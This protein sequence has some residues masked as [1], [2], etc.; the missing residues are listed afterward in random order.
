MAHSSDD[1]ATTP[2]TEAEDAAKDPGREFDSIVSRI[3][4]EDPTAASP[5]PH[6]AEA[7]PAPEPKPASGAR[8]QPA[9]R[10]KGGF[11]GVFLGGVCAAMLGFAAATYVLP[12]L[13]QGWL[14]FPL[15]DPATRA[16]L[17]AQAARIESMAQEIA[18]LQ[19]APAPIDGAKLDAELAR[20]RDELAAVPA[21]TPDLG[22]LEARLS[23]LDARLSIIEK[24]PVAGGA[25]SSTAIDALGRELEA[26]RAEVAQQQSAGGGQDAARI[27]AAATEAQAQIK[28][29]TEE[30][31]RLKSEAEDIARRGRVESALRLIQAGMA[32]GGPFGAAI[33]DLT[34]AGI[35]VPAELAQDAEGI[36][37]LDQLRTSFPDSARQA[38]LVAAKPAPGASALDRLGAFLRGQS[39]AR[40]LTPRAG[41]DPDAI[42]SRAEA[43]LNDGDLAAALNEV[44]SL[45][46]EVQAPMADWIRLTEQR[47]A[48]LDAVAAL[49]AKVN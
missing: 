10:R 48:A 38:L 45:P 49:S 43:A 36:P 13:P 40:S 21:V 35:E 42:L 17:D 1:P 41:T 4:S 7:D 3:E 26:L 15:D 47:R 16:T 2:P 30:A 24:R 28:A 9:P 46:A 25:A 19:Q 34:A 31:A 12:K 6:T 8:I 32:S 33:E 22:P 18:A 14:P 29:A 39:G 5:R 37:T 11:A 20:V 27:A 44:R 23:D